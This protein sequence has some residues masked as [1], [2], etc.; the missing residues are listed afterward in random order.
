MVL[1][2]LLPVA[3]VASAAS[4]PLQQLPCFIANTYEQFLECTQK[5]EMLKLLHDKISVHE[6]LMK[7]WGNNHGC[8]H[9]PKKE[10]VL[11]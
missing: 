7:L 10:A 6:G 5:H 3:T 2:L 11:T 9:P 8:H 4:S 1:L